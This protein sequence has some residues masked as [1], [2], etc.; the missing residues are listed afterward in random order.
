M[1]Y[2]KSHLLPLKYRIKQAYDQLSNIQYT[3]EGLIENIGEFISNIFRKIMEFFF[4]KS[5]PANKVAVAKKRYIS[6]THNS[7]K[8]PE[9]S[10]SDVASASENQYPNEHEI[11]QNLH[12]QYVL[13]SEEQKNTLADKTFRVDPVLNYSKLN[14]DLLT[15]SDKALDLIKEFSE[16][17]N[18][19]QSI[20]DTTDLSKFNVFIEKVSSLIDID[21]LDE[22]TNTAIH[23]HCGRF[24]K[25]KRELLDDFLINARSTIDRI[26]T[27]LCP[28]FDSISTSVGKVYMN[29][30]KLINVRSSNDQAADITNKLKQLLKHIKKLWSLYAIPCSISC[31][32]F[33]VGCE[34][35]TIK[36][37]ANQIA[38]K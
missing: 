32:V 16:L 8:S 1:N 3:N 35:R 10:S 30:E 7:V 37:N 27:E 33:N 25:Y 23:T 11:Y 6:A 22:N 14:N 24:I 26:L 9:Y 17:I 29:V 5:S 34:L 12:A 15:Q 28:K 21:A 13:L 36:T 2:N 20:D 4:G 31:T 38:S 19:I 18:T